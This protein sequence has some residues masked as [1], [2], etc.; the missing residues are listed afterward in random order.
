MRSLCAFSFVFALNLVVL[1]T[2]KPATKAPTTGD[3]ASTFVATNTPDK[4]S[5]NSELDPG[6]LLSTTPDDGHS[7]CLKMRTY[8][9]RRESPDSDVVRP[10][11]YAT[12]MNANKV[13]MESATEPK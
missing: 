6:V 4:F 3:Q 11:G 9:V 10:A 12:C 2:D 7:Y 1:A 13:R 8:K 5:F